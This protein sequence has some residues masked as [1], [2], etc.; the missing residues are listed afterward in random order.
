MPNMYWRRP[1]KVNT[2]YRLNSVR[3]IVFIYKF[4]KNVSRSY[5]YSSISLLLNGLE[6]WWIVVVSGDRCSSLM[7]LSTVLK[8]SGYTQTPKTAPWHVKR[9]SSNVKSITR[10]CNFKLGILQ[11]LHVVFIRLGWGKYLCGSCVRIRFVSYGFPI[12]IYCTVSIKQK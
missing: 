12:N 8:C 4:F 3:Q 1:W 5:Q 11:R 2:K 7:L 9:A 6:C 10:R